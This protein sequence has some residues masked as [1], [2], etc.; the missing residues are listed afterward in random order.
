M[1]IVSVIDMINT[2][3]NFLLILSIFVCRYL[4]AA[5]LPNSQQSLRTNLFTDFEKPIFGDSFSMPI[6]LSQ[7]YTKTLQIN[8][9]SVVGQQEE[10]IV[11]FFLLAF[12]IFL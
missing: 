4:R 3:K 2:N 10:I 11:S 8:V 7:I 9:Q 5:L 6:P 1:S 12:S